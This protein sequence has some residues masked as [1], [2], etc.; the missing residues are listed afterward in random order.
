MSPL[1]WQNLRFKIKLGMT[2]FGSCLSTFSFSQTA[3]LSTPPSVNYPGIIQ[4]FEKIIQVDSTKVTNQLEGLIKNGKAFA[5]SSSVKGVELDKDFLNS[6]ILH[7][8]AG[9][10]KL[11]SIDRCRFYDTI[12][13]DLLKSA[14]GKIKNIVISH[15]AKSGSRELAV[16]TKKDFL[17]KVVNQ[18]CPETAKL[19]NLFQV[20]TLDKVV[21]QTPF[22]IPTNRDQ[23]RNT[24][25]SWLSNPQTPY[26]CQIHEYLKEVKNRRGDPKD[27]PQR[28]AMA[29]IIEQKL[30][31]LQLD[32]L[33][34]LCT[35]LDH[36]EL[37][38]N[39]FLNVPFWS[40]VAGGYEDKIYAEGICKQLVGREAIS[41]IQMKQC[42]ARIKKENDLCH[43]AGGRSASLQPQPGCD[44]LSLALNFSS[45]RSNYADC[46]GNSD[47]LAATN[48]ARILLNINNTPLKP[49]AGVC[50]VVSAGEVHAFN[51][52][53]DNDENWTLQACYDDKINEKEVCQKFFFGDYG[54]SPQSFTNVVAEILRNTRGAERGLRCQMVDS[55]DYNPLLLQYKS[56]CYVI[57]ERDQCFLSYCKHKILYNDRSIDFIIIKNR[58]TI[59]YFPLSVKTERFS[60]HYLLTRD[61]KRTGRSLNNLTGILS[62][63]KKGKKTVL[64]GVGCAEDLLPSF[65]K[66]KSL[67]QCTGLPFII[68]GLI[69]ENDRVAFVTRTAA[70]NLQSPRLMSW[71]NIYSSV[72]AYQQTHPLKIWT[73]YGLD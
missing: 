23:C 30:S 39:E 2:L 51:Q 34:N 4:T 67:N 40:K 21:A 3:P 17:N 70:D 52:K 38:C 9:Y 35:N 63:F 43:Y 68:D 8:D 69:K 50:S 66:T 61:F 49:Q 20:K 59:E 71:S 62:F 29:K 36:E 55:Q 24:H 33:E 32:Y 5:E 41:D 7:S 46:P 47:Q 27:L 15:E 14:E 73:L 58:M 25:T 18:D 19:I 42:L 44:E 26:F 12:I 65:F 6:I 11:A 1:F 48:I 56:G 64:Y 31:L 53:F 72:K 16:I 28:Q 13:T 10:L 60:Q 54:A 37:F 22:E 57:Y 45:L